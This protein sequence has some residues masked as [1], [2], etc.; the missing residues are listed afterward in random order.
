MELQ[1]YI[2]G[3]VDDPC[4]TAGAFSLWAGSYCSY[5]DYRAWRNRARSLFTGAIQPAYWAYAAARFDSLGRP[6]DWEDADEPLFLLLGQ[7]SDAYNKLPVPERWV[8]AESQRF[9]VQR[10]VTLAVL[11]DQLVTKLQAATRELGG[12]VPPVSGTSEES[13]WQLP[14][15]ELP[16]L[17]SFDEMPDWQWPVVNL[18]VPWYVWAGGALGVVAVGTGIY[19][20]VT[21]KRKRRR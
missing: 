19:F 5:A 16:D 13:G 14:D 20:A 12:V 18:D 17:P 7:Y 21:P 2:G 1:N 9:Y 3:T 11:G 15:F 10:A 6:D 4:P 8:S